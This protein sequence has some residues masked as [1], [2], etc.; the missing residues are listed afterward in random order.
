MGPA[1]SMRS[2][3]ST[4]R[5]AGTSP[6]KTGA[7]DTASCCSGRTVRAIAIRRP[8]SWR[9][10]GTCPVSRACSV[11][12]TRTRNPSATPCRP[13]AFDWPSS[14]PLTCKPAVPGA[15][16][17][18]PI[19]SPARRDHCRR[20]VGN[21]AQCCAHVTLR[22]TPLPTL[23]PVAKRTAK[24][25]EGAT[26]KIVGFE[27]NGALHLGVVEGDQ[28][29]DLQA[30]DKAIPGDLGECLRRNNGDLSP[31]KD[32]AKRAPASARRPLKG[33]T[34]GLPV[35][36]PGKV[37]C[38]GLNYLEHVKEGSQRDNVPKF[39]TIFM[40]GRTSLV[41]HGQPIIRPKA[42]ETL[43]YE[44][45]LIFIVGKRAKHLTTANAY[46][47]IAGYSCGNEGSV[48]EYQR[49]TTQWDMGKNFDRTGGFG[50]WM[51]TVDELPAG[52]KGLKI[53]TRLN[54]QVMQSDNTDNMMFPIAETIAYITQGMTLEPGDIVFTGTPSGVGHA[55]KPNPVWMKQD[56]TCEIDIEGIGVLVNPIE[57]EK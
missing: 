33:L 13:A 25:S 30:V 55:R 39:P 42:S 7:T 16:C 24:S 52:G 21:G 48:R 50:P 3:A 31:L 22:S 14:T 32:A 1:G 2:C 15:R 53:Q 8:R 4:R 57:N 43:D 9:R 19:S 23:P 46:S 26:M 5:G 12:F 36:A 56:D 17:C 27:A 20:R 54:G 28:V 49:K 6:S 18:G 11:R 47:C 44:A 10:C 37:I 35:A 29:I 34:Y 45:E 51:V 38:L 40:R 41:P